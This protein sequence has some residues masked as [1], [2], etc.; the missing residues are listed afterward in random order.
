MLQERDN[1]SRMSEGLEM[2]RD[3]C[4]RRP[5]SITVRGQSPL[6]SGAHTPE[7]AKDI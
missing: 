7:K 5:K 3:G 6:V 2:T 1:Q 4:N